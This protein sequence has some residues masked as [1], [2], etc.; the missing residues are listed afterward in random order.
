M[1]TSCALSDAPYR[2]LALS[3]GLRHDGWI[4]GLEETLRATSKAPPQGEHDPMLFRPER[5]PWPEEHIALLRRKPGYERTPEEEEQIREQDACLLRNDIFQSFADDRKVGIVTQVYESFP[6][7]DI[8]SSRYAMVDLFNAH[9]RRGTGIIGRTEFLYGESVVALD[10]FRR[11]FRKQV[12]SGRFT[13]VLLLAL[14]WHVDQIEAIHTYNL[15]LHNLKTVAGDDFQ[16]LVVGITWPSAWLQGLIQPLDWVGHILSYFDKSRDADAFGATWINYLLHDVLLD[17][18]NPLP[19]VAIGHSMGARM[20][21]RACFSARH[22]KHARRH[23]ALS[24]LVCL[25]GAF[26]ARRFLVDDSDEGGP[27]ASFSSKRARI[28]LTTSERD[29]A[30]KAARILTT[31]PNV[32]GEYGLDVAREHPEVFSILNWPL[33]SSR[34][35]PPYRDTIFPRGS[36]RVVMIDAEEIVRGGRGGLHGTA[37]GAH[38]DF[39]DE[40]MAELLW[41]LIRCT[42]RH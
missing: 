6:A 33:S 25:Q 29:L 38:N 37:V 41:T 35:S 16:P 28:V 17:E 9:D 3:R 31:F 8:N 14:G 23:K 10:I 34:G 24:L 1:C 26:S 15:M 30:N 13:H 27:Y 40:E 22:L 4:I 21:S 36:R 19:V 5:L 2:Q 12:H 39:V 32:G 42:T 7:S 18:E 20:L 11:R